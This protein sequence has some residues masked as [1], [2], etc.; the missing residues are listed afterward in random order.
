MPGFYFTAPPY[1]D[2]FRVWFHPV[3]VCVSSEYFLSTPLLFVSAVTSIAHKPHEG[4][5]S[6][7]PMLLVVETLFLC[8]ACGLSVPQSFK[9]IEMRTSMCPLGLTDVGSVLFSVRRP[10]PLPVKPKTWLLG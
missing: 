9:T 10:S 4:R 6:R 3:Y 8:E 5:T 1:L 2:N 7:L